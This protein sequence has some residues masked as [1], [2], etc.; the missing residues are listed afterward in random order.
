[1][2]THFSITRYTPSSC[3]AF[4]YI[5]KHKIVDLNIF[6]IKITNMH[7]T[8]QSIL[9]KPWEDYTVVA[10]RIFHVISTR[11]WYFRTKLLK[12][13]IFNILMRYILL[14]GMR[15][16][17]WGGRAC[18]LWVINFQITQN[19]VNFEQSFIIN[20]NIYDVALKK[21]SFGR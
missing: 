14:G 8:V 5:R 12:R 20:I 10:K 2:A 21:L 1:M 19:S 18:L 6:L 11:I 7:Y 4:H 15:V 17:V 9:R 13:N 3:L 16:C